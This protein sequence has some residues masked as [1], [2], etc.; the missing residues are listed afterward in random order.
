[1]GQEGAH[2]GAQDGAQDGGHRVLL[3]L[4]EGDEVEVAQEAV[5]DHLAAAPRRAH[6]ADE[7]DV[8]DPAEL[9]GLAVVPAALVHPLAQELHRGLRAVLL[10]LGHVDVVHHDREALARGGRVD[11]LAA[12]LE[13]AV[14]EVLR[15]VCAR[16]CGE[17]YEDGAEVLGHA[18]HELVLDVEGLA[19]AR[20]P[21]AEHVVTADHEALREPHVAHRVSH[22]HDDVR[23][24]RLGREHELVDG[25]HPRPPGVGVEVEGKVVDGACLGHARGVHEAIGRDGLAEPAVEEP[26]AL[27]VARAADAPDKGEEERALRHRWE[28][29]LLLLR[30]LVAALTGHPLGEAALEHAQRRVHEVVAY[31]LHVV[32]HV[33]A[34]EVEG[35]VQECAEELEHAWHH[36]LRGRGLRRGPGRHLRRGANAR[37]G[38]HVDDA[39]A[40][41]GRGGR[42]GEVLHLKDDVHARGHGDDLAGDEAEFL[43]VVEH[44]VHVLDPDGV[45]G[46]VEDDPLAVECLVGHRHAH[47]RGHEAVA[48]LLG[49]G[50]H[51]PVEL[52]HRNRL[53]VERVPVCH[54]VVR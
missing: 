5:R 46:A 7:G 10:A 6:A 50:V 41:H 18:C 42:D 24:G 51:R 32:A 38:L 2:E 49:H 9:E 26:A 30:H 17:V 21:H 34:H 53:W 13:L 37:D 14:E 36:G 4:G 20:G 8:D 28:H 40:A 23:E 22:G 31:G 12:L 54:L 44:R 11:A 47:E 25:L 19:R 27:G 39:H 48:P 52:A 1:M 3:E 29:R 45:H 16:L 43:V 35:P 15:L 33:L